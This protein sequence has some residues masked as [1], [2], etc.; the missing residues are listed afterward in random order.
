MIM[1]K[2]LLAAAL[3]A[4]LAG[5]KTNEANYRQAYEVAKQKFENA[6]T[7]STGSHKLERYAQP[8][9]SVVGSDTIKVLTEPLGAVRGEGLTSSQIRRYNVVA[10]R[11]RQIFNARQ[12]RQRLIAS[13][14]GATAILASPMPLYYVVTISTDT[15]ADA[16]EEIHRL[17][18]DTTLRFR[19]PLP[20]VLSPR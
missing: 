17:E 19:A 20:F 6:D 16:V 8:H 18:S 2:I 11:F 13:G 1:K 14:Y 12:M 9:V 7:V 15:V 3:C 4:L 10:G 5:C